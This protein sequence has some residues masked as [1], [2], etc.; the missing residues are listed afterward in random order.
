MSKVSSAQAAQWRD[1]TEKPYADQ[2]KWFLNGASFF[3]SFVYWHCF[4]TQGF[5]GEV[6]QEAET[7]W[8]FCMKFSELDQE[9]KAAG[10]ELD[11][12]WSHK[13]PTNYIL[14]F[15]LIFFS[16]WKLL[17]KHWLLLLCVSSCA[18]LMLVRHN[19]S[20]GGFQTNS[21]F[22]IT[23]RKWAWLSISCSDTRRVS[24]K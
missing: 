20:C 9:K 12:F 22:K 17:E 4:C 7:I 14:C 2:C 11:E 19:L 16:S 15:L 8:G 1:I 13:V 3:S 5:W 10:N 23:T 21:L 18:K 24:S 6:E